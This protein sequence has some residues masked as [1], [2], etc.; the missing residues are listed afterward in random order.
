MS[1][2]DCFQPA[3]ADAMEREGG[4]FLDLCL[5]SPAFADAMER[6]GGGFLDLIEAFGGP[7]F[8]A[9]LA[10]IHALVRGAPGVRR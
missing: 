5:F 3:F 1:R 7:A 8:E 4:G 10:S 6:E 2:R 9:L